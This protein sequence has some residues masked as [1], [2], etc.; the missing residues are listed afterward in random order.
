[1]AD[2]TSGFWHW[3]IAIG[4]VL[5]ILALFPLIFMNRG[6]KPEGDPETSGHVWDEDL[7]EYN[8]PLPSWWLNLFIITLVFAL[9]YLTL[10]PG[11]GSFQGLL[12][13]SSKGQY[14]EEIGFAKERFD[15]IFEQYASLSPSDL[16][17]NADAM[18]TG[19]RLFLNNCAQCHGS[20]AYGA[21]GF[22]NLVDNDWQWGSEHEQIYQT[23]INGRIAAM[24]PW[25]TPLGGPDGV[26]DV[27]HYVLNLSG[28]E[29]NAEFASAGKAKY[30]Q[31]CAACHQPN[32]S[33]NV[34]LGAPNIADNIWLYGG[35]YDDIYHSIAIG[36]NG[37]MPAFNNL[38]GEDRVYLLSAY[39]QSLG[40]Q[41]Q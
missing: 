18:R 33:G 8:N 32:G 24:P 25:E 39:V 3:F 35:S 16:I 36:R 5:S 27:T 13:W 38:L 6:H 4:T 9:V 28:Q 26:R 1:M 10:Y 22:P 2:F 29:H 17:A 7:T 41:N 23:I 12:G 14:Q 20:D 31:L 11:L 21:S 19:K 34:L 15:P 40:E 30:D 37:V